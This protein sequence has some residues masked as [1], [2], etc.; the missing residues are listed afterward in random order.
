MVMTTSTDDFLALYESSVDAVYRYASRLTGGD[1]VRT[2]EL[3]QD[4]F[5]GVLERI[6][7]GE[8]LQITTGY[9]IVA[10]RH[11]FLDDLKAQRRRYVREHRSSR[12]HVVGD[13][14]L[15]T[16][17][18]GATDALAD[19][20]NDQRAAMVMRYIDD[21]PVA[22]VARELGRSVGATESLL[23]RARTTLRAV[24]EQGDA[25]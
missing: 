1:R 3:V 21:L 25:S 4:T 12:L 5:L 23:V 6:Q 18:R 14:V 7:R 13:S 15:P 2:D 10:C 8:R 22:A 19:L 11:L 9:L 16:S 24:L 20:P 17:D